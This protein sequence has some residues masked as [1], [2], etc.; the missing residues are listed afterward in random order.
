M[1]YKIITKD[2]LEDHINQIRCGYSYEGEVLYFMNS[3][4]IVIGLLK[5]KTIWYIMCR[6]TREFLWTACL[7]S[8]KLISRA[9]LCYISVYPDQP[10]STQI[11]KKNIVTDQTDF[12]T[13]DLDVTLK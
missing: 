10:C 6:V 3:S 12:V 2:Q 1:P 4:N 7:V 9:T 11:D 13:F 5:K 8:I